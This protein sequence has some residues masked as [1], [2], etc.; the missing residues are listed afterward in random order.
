MFFLYVASC[1]LFCHS[2]QESHRYTSLSLSSDYFVSSS[3]SFCILSLQGPYSLLPMQPKSVQDEAWWFLQFS[4]VCLHIQSFHWFPTTFST[5]WSIKTMNSIV[6]SSVLQFHPWAV[7]KLPGG[8][9]PIFFTHI[10]SANFLP[11]VLSIDHYLIY[12][13]KPNNFR[14]QF[15]S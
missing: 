12:Y 15:E 7:P 4:G 1:Q 2:S 14:K 10:Y 9:S 13:F 6:Q 5:L 3:D 11:N 8:F